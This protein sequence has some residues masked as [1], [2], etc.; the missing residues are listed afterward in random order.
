MTKTK[1]LVSSQ[2]IIS[3]IIGSV[4]QIARIPPNNKVFVNNSITSIVKYI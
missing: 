3:S 1:A 2:G 4:E